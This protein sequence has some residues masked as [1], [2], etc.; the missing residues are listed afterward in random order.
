M[1]KLVEFLGGKKVL[2]S[3]SVI[4]IAIM[5]LGGFL[6]NVVATDGGK[7]SMT[8][9]SFKGSADNVVS[10]FMFQ[11]NSASAE[12]KAPAVILAYGGTGLKDFMVNI[13]IELA[14]RGIVA[15]PVD[16]NGCGATEYS[17]SIVAVDAL[18]YL[19]SQPFVDENNIGVV[20]QSF[21]KMFAWDILRNQ[22]D[23][24]K[25]IAYLG[26]TP[27]GHPM[28]DSGMVTNEEIYAIKNVLYV[29]GT[30]EETALDPFTI[31]YNASNF[32]ENPLWDTLIFKGQPHD[33]ICKEHTVYGNIEDGTA[34]MVVSPN[35]DHASTTESTKSV[36]AVVEWMVLTLGV[37]T[38]L[39][40]TNTIMQMKKFYVSVSFVAM[41]LFMFTAGAAFVKSESYADCLAPETEYKGLTKAGYWIGAVITTALGPLTWAASWFKWP[42]VKGLNTQLPFPFANAYAS[43]FIVLALI[44]AALLVINYFILR[45]KGF[46]F[47]DT[48]LSC[49]LK[50]FGKQAGMAV[51]IFVII[52]AVGTF[53]YGKFKMPITLSGIPIP[54]MFRP[55]DGIRLP[56]LL[57]YFLVYLPYYLVLAVLLFG[58]L[59]PKN[60]TLA[61]WKE[62]LINVAV[63]AVGPIVFLLGYYLPLYAGWGINPLYT[64]W[65]IANGAP[66]FM[67]GYFGVI[68]IYM[69]PVPIINAITACGMTYF[70]RKTGKVW[71][72]AILMALLFA[73]MQVSTVNFASAIFG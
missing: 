4:L 33:E 72:A 31:N 23:W 14:R 49:S 3:T 51:L 70:G 9:V 34:R 18:S 68:M 17:S 48:G 71:F 57:N 67:S 39:S 35:I 63:L 12:N 56:Y 36:S 7:T 46:T 50:D 28:M 40:A 16:T 66:I 5:I 54:I 62:M 59:R 10:A 32:F 43:W 26:I 61:L 47:K 8:E 20:V 55:L 19:R 73:W 53:I 60:G 21:G 15:M 22:P 2:I 38:N 27:W 6:G 29:F 25:S 64:Q 24:Y 13:S 52:Y 69:I 44:T 11:P 42:I 41:I 1:K 65:Q 30:A 37:K 45:R 58:F